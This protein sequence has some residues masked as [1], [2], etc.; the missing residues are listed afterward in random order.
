MHNAL[1]KPSIAGE[2]VEMIGDGSCRLHV[3]LEVVHHYLEELYTGTSK[4]V[5]LSCNI[6]TANKES[7]DTSSISC[8]RAH[9]QRPLDLAGSHAV[10]IRSR[11]RELPSHVTNVNVELLYKIT[12]GTY[13]FDAKFA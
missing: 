11:G 8:K 9:L 4:E 5:S 6:M 1:P 3:E 10:D 12:S 2:V 13:Y 7:I